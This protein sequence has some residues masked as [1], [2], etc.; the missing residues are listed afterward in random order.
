MYPGMRHGLE[1]NWNTWLLSVPLECNNISKLYL[2]FWVSDF[3]LFTFARLALPSHNIIDIN[4]LQIRSCRHLS[5]AEWTVQV[6][7]PF[8]VHGRK[9]L[10]TILENH[11]NMLNLEIC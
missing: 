9:G 6:C 10:D 2:K 8:K 4:C 7:F 11:M 5:G 3:V 1:G